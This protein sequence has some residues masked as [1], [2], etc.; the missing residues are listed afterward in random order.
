MAMVVVVA[1]AFM[2]VVVMVIYRPMAKQRGILKTTLLP[3]THLIIH[4]TPFL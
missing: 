2:V 3:S 4:P 1:L